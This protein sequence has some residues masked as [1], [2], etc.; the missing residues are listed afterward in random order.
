MICV[1]VQFLLDSEKSYKEVCVEEGET[2]SDLMP[3]IGIY[4]EDYYIFVVNGAVRFKNYV[5]M[6]GD[7]VKVFIAMIGG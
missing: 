3:K 4:R 2:L 6:E 5:L 7:D 1:K